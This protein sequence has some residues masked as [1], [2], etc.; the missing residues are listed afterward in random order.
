MEEEEEERSAKKRWKIERERLKAAFVRPHHDYIF[1]SRSSLKN[2]L[3]SRYSLRG[4][5]GFPSLFG[6]NMEGGGGGGGEGP[7]S[8]L[9][10]T[11][12]PPVMMSFAKG[13]G[14]T[15]VERGLP[16][17]PLGYCTL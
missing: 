12:P 9:A 5:K 15:V 17:F 3:F 16:P 4:V 10:V 1:F 6:V 8:F 13:T 2:P 11:P 14:C 7:F